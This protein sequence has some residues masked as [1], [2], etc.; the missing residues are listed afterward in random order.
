M[1]PQVIQMMQEMLAKGQQEKE[2]EIKVM[3][4][5]T[6][7]VDDTTRQLGFEIKTAK[8][9]IEKL[10]AF[11][12][13]AVADIAGLSDEIAVLDGDIATWEGDQK[14]AT[15]IRDKEKGEYEVEQKDLS[16]SVDALGRAIQV[17]GNVQADTPQAAA[18]L[19]RIA[20]ISNGVMGPQGGSAWRTVELRLEHERD[21][22][23][24]SAP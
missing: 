5:Y 7:W 15:A 4:E 18:R 12:E 21:R 13:K 14:A 19:T 17:L 2:A 1:T 6:E 10:S 24:R 9:A 22:S 20:A 3:D 8:A 23:K 11:I 16:E